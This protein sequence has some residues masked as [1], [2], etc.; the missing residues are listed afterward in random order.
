LPNHLENIHKQ[1]NKQSNNPKGPKSLTKRPKCVFR[2]GPGQI[3]ILKTHQKKKKE[4]KE[5]GVI[6]YDPI[7]GT[8]IKLTGVSQIKAV[9]SYIYFCLQSALHGG[10]Y[11]FQAKGKVHF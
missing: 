6:V 9:S 11:N 10:K 7:A 1:S 2:A 8:H 4:N 3:S 5:D